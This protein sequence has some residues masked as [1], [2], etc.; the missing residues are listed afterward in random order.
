MKTLVT[1]KSLSWIQ[2]A[3]C[4]GPRLSLLGL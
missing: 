2:K 3:H 4:S 1:I